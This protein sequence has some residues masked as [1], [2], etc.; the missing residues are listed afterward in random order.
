LRAGQLRG[1]P[2]K[3]LVREHTRLGC[4][5]IGI[6]VSPYRGWPFLS[7]AHHPFISAVWAVLI[8]GVIALIV[9]GPIIWRARHRVAWG[10]FAFAGG[11]ALDLDHF[12]AAGSLSLHRIETLSGRPDTHSLAFVLAL[13]LV[14]FFVWPRA[15]RL[16]AAW[17]L[18]AV[19]TAHLLFDASG[20]S[21]HILY[22]WTAVNGIPWLLCPLGTLAL[23][24]ASEA[25]ARRGGASH[26]AA[27]GAATPAEAGS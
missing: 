18:F 13:S 22:P 1:E 6:G 10:A 23:C 7:D 5:G 27:P 21:E 20:G 17:S 9:V 14:T 3:A 2:A 16:T 25:I 12:I 24:A 15:S 19:N 8:H 4:Q 11:S 26:A